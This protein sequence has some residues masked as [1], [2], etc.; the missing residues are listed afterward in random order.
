MNEKNTSVAIIGAGVSG[1]AHAKRCKDLGCEFVVFEKSNKIGGVW[2]LFANKT[3]KV[4]VDCVAYRFEEDSE[5]VFTNY[6]PRDELMAHLADFADRYQISDQIKF[7]TT[8]T[9]LQYQK[10]TQ[11]CLVKFIGPD[12]K[13]Q[14]M[15]FDKVLINTGSL[16]KPRR[17]TYSGEDDFKGDLI[18]G[19]SDDYD[20]SK[21]KDKNVVVVGAGAFAV[22]NARVAI[23]H[24]AKKV[25]MIAR[26]PHF[27]SGRYASYLMQKTCLEAKNALSRA[28]L[29]K[30]W[31][32]MNE[33]MQKLQ[34]STGTDTLFEKITL[35]FLNM[36]HYQIYSIPAASD[37]F[38]LMLYYGLLEIKEK[39]EIAYL[40]ESSVT[41]KK[42]NTY[43]AD[44]IVKCIGFETDTSLLNKRPI[45]SACFAEGGNMAHGIKT[46][47]ISSDGITIGPFSNFNLV[48]VSY[49]NTI[50][51][52]AIPELLI[53][54]KELKKL[55]MTNPATTS[56]DS[57]SSNDFNAYIKAIFL[58]SSTFRKRLIEKNLASLS[59]Y[60]EQLNERVFHLE[61][62]REWDDYCQ[63]FS[64]ITNKPA[65]EYPFDIPSQAAV[66]KQKKKRIKSPLFFNSLLSL[67]LRLDKLIGVLT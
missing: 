52:L 2:H 32:R 67:G 1:L 65:L 62:K 36:D 38:Y 49:I 6:T 24:G 30:S 22:E 39:D 26:R 9:D 44:V 66:D 35:D 7:E 58:Q 13:E 3:S 20:P 15:E 27:V 31:R 28:S 50:E 19:I 60:D 11:K 33:S 47:N 18:Y 29:L 59:V 53:K 23:E 51:Q 54:E 48:N 8:V 61:N 10:E 56:I 46:D 12:Q 42:G 34:K 45:N 21:F 64:D 41:T 4:Q 55:L 16:N 5:K 40:N 37:V 43:P 57:I 17:L 14:V 63:K 25:T